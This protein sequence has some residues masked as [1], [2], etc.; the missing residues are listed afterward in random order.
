M[1]KCAV[2]MNKLN[3][4]DK[5]TWWELYFR[6]VLKQLSCSVLLSRDRHVTVPK[7]K[8]SWHDRN[9]LIV[10]K[11]YSCETDCNGLPR[12]LPKNI[13]FSH[14]VHSKLC[15]PRTHRTLNTTINYYLTDNFSPTRALTPKI[16]QPPFFLFNLS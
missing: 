3:K 8:K 5:L 1:Y 2:C 16:V 14:E 9:R 13:I 7:S 4:P 10:T 12:T 6:A 11:S 15:E